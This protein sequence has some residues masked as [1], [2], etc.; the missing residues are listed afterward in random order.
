MKIYDGGS[1]KDALIISASGNYTPSQVKSLRSQM[2][3][4]FSH[5]NGIYNIVKGFTAKIRFGIK[6]YLHETFCFNLS[7]DR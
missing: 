4:M 6:S 7:I 5:D 1:N 3:L 2:F